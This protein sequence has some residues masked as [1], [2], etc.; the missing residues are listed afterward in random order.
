GDAVADLDDQLAVPALAVFR[1]EADVEVGCF[2]RFD[3]LHRLVE[4]RLVGGNGEHVAQGQPTDVSRLHVVGAQ[5]G[6]IGVDEVEIDNLAGSITYRPHDHEA[7]HR[8]L[9]RHA[10][11]LL[12]LG[13]LQPGAYHVGDVVQHQRHDVAVQC[14]AGCV[15][16]HGAGA[17]A[18]HR[19]GADL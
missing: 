11:P 16:E 12:L 10:K 19:G 6:R 5:C 1:L 13:E 9:L 15:P 8:Q 18:E 17:R 3:D 7:D 4:Q 2:A 14:Q